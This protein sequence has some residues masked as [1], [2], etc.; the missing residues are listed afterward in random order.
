MKNQ[1]SK[2]N[3]PLKSAT[4][5]SRAA[6]W[7]TAGRRTAEPTSPSQSSVSTETT[8]VNFAAH[9]ASGAMTFVR[10]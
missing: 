4:E 8:K 6:I 9:T 10:F 7:K 5:T 1:Q 2:Q 3:Q